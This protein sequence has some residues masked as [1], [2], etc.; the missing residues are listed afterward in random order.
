M[1]AV[2]AVPATNPK[3]DKAGG[4]AVPDGAPAA[5]AA[6]AVAG[7]VAPFPGGGNQVA[8]VAAA[9]GAR[10]MP[11]IF[12]PVPSRRLGRSL[13]VDCVPLKHC[14]FSCCY[15]QL[16]HSPQTTCQRQRW[17]EPQTLLAELE[18]KLSSQPDT[19]TLSGS[20]EP[21]LYAG[22]EELITGIKRLTTTALTVLS[23]GSLFWLPEVRRAVLPADRIVPSLDAADSATFERINHPHPQITLPRLLD[24]LQALRQ[25]YQGQFWLEVFLLP[26]INTQGPP[27][28]HLLQAVANLQPHKI[29]LNTVAR[30][31][32]DAELQ[33]VPPAEMAQLAQRFGPQAEVIAA[34]G[35]AVHDEP[36]F[37]ACQDDIICLVQRRPVTQDDICQGLGLH[38]NEASKYLQELLRQQRLQ[39]RQHGGHNYFYPAEEQE[40]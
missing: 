29:Q 36:G 8:G 19:I 32:A 25:E 28:E 12:G 24:G 14:T 2:A 5:A 3:T 21:T 26:G 1:G 31:P 20:G 16:G 7:E 4:R 11:G 38:P 10:A 39:Q 35:T 9:T 22:L 17:V 37:Q 34:G 6:L 15:C 18:Q 13:G 33:A 27:L 40:G 23:N 30:P